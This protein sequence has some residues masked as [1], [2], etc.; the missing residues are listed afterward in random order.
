VTPARTPDGPR[1]LPLDGEGGAVAVDTVFPVM[2]GP[3]GEDG[4]VQGALEAAGF[5]YVGCGVAASAACM[6]KDHTKAILRRAGLPVAAWVTVARGEP[7]DP[8]AVRRSLGAPPWFVKPA[9]M[10]SS[11][12]ISRVTREDRLEAALVRAFEHDRKALVETEVAGRE[13]E[14]AVLGNDTPRAS[15]V[16]E[17]AVRSRDGFY[18]YAAK[19]LEDDA[20]ELHLQARLEPEIR[21]QIRDAAVRAFRALGCRGLARVDF[22]LEPEGEIRVNEL[23]TM[24]GFT[25]ISMYPKLWEH[26]GLP[27]AELVARLVE[28]AHER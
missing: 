2:H 9:N 5:P 10:G 26:A 4:T 11:V 21:D 23:N 13:L 16:G 12:G 8:P 18:D 20:A 17:I 3:F 6:D 14:C 19:Y 7:I 22:F 1:F 27:P 24:P 15:G 28:L 25:S